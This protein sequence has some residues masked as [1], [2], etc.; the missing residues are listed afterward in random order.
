VRGRQKSA[1]RSGLFRGIFDALRIRDEGKKEAVTCN[2]SLAQHS[3]GG[4]PDVIAILIILGLVLLFYA[5]VLALL[6]YDGVLVPLAV[7]VICSGAFF[8]F[9][10]SG[11]LAF[12]LLAMAWA[13]AF[14]ALSAARRRTSE[15]ALNVIRDQNDLLR[16]QIKA[17]KS[18]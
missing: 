7:L 9:F 11:P 8:I 16:R 4:T 14:A 10:V 6:Y 2:C 17:T 1:A 5:P 13:C 15:A 12:I 3:H 18:K